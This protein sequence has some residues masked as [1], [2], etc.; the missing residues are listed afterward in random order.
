MAHPSRR[1]TLGVGA[2][3]IA[4]FGFGT[5]AVLAAI[6]FRSGGNQ[7]ALLVLRT[8]IA[9]GAAT[10]F[11]AARGEPIRL[12]QRERLGCA[13]IG[14]ITAGQSFAYFTAFQ[15]IPVS[16][17]TLI[18]YLYPLIVALVRRAT[19]R[20][21]LGPLQ[22]AA[23]GTA[24]LG[25]A[26]ALDVTGEGIDWRGVVFALIDAFSSAAITLLGAR[27]LGGAGT[28]QLT[29]H[30]SA[31]SLVT[32]LLCAELAG[33]GLHLPSDAG[34]WSALA[35][36]PFL[37]LVGILGFFKGIQTIGPTRT[38]MVSNIEPVV[39]LVLAALLLDE[40]LSLQQL[41]G[42]A[43]VIGAVVATQIAR[44]RAGRAG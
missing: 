22:L 1:E 43:L 25:L 20:E 7:F 15:F 19:H 39:I 21:P 31:V 5:S 12:P 18:V 24:F 34:G 28:M 38:T 32:L 33:F 23:L 40:S 16:L 29:I 6:I 2:V 13:L 4:A 26:L 3:V 11:L 14:L 36:A 9:A 30:S 17:A 44:A 37:Y 8:A 42:A 27:V 10:L 41:L 35:A